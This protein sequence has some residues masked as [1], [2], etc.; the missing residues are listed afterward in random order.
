MPTGAPG[1]RRRDRLMP[2]GPAAG[3]GTGAGSGA[4]SGWVRAGQ[5][6]RSRGGRRGPAGVTVRSAGRGRAVVPGRGP[7]P[8]GRRPSRGHRRPEPVL[9]RAPASAPGGAAGASTQGRREQHTGD[10]RHHQARGRTRP[11]TRP[12]GV[13]EG[14][15]T[16]VVERRRGGDQQRQQ[17]AG[18]GETGQPGVR[19]GR[20]PCPRRASATAPAEREEPDQVADPEAADLGH[21]GRAPGSCRVPSGPPFGTVITSHSPTS[22]AT[23]ATAPRPA[24]QQGQ[25]AVPAQ[26]GQG[27]GRTGGAV[28]PFGR[29]PTPSRRC[30]RTRSS[31]RGM[32]RSCGHRPPSAGHGPASHHGTA[33]AP[34]VTGIARQASGRSV[35]RRSPFG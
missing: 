22:E 29:H 27:P 28:R 14:P 23:A 7:A 10:E 18:Q 5:A 26:P 3:A 17:G 13:E 15:L 33:G 16:G 8:A 24:Q 1:C 4:S 12:R 6:L 11:G 32:G 2:R 31:C 21:P 9:V 34:C 25:P 19:A 30:R 35:A 20:P